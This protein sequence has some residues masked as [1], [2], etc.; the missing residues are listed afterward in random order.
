MPRDSGLDTL[1]NLAGEIYDQ[2]DGYWIKIEA[3]R[4]PPTAEIPHG[5]R[6]SLTLHGPDNARILG[7][8]NAHALQPRHRKFAG[9]RIEFD[10]RHPDGVR[11][12]TLYEFTDPAQLLSDFFDSVDRALAAR[13]RRK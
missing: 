7:F 13:R 6:Y 2:G 4:V 1:L 9:R 12:A 11:P 5:I 3:W 8:D 10:H